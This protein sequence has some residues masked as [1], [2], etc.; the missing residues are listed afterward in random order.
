M[1]MYQSKGNLD[2]KILF[3]KIPHL[4]DQ[5]IKKIPVKRM[6]GNKDST[7]ILVDDLPS[8]EIRIPFLKLVM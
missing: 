1:L 6:F 4:I 8:I 5:K 2:E 7:F 3:G